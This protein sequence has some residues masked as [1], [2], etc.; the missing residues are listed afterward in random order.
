MSALSD[1]TEA[2]DPGL[3]ALGLLLRL[4]G[5]TVEADQI[6]LR[7]GA[8]PIG[9]TEMLRGAKKFGLNTVISRT[10]REGLAALL[11]AIATLRDGGF[12]L[13]GKVSEEGVVV[14]RPSS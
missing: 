13:V 9:T 3:I 7:C 11:P 6:R 4:H 12:L 8:A 14:V 1:D 2:V 10:N 5:V